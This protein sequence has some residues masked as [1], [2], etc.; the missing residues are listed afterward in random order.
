MPQYRITRPASDN[1]GVTCRHRP[2]TEVSFRFGGRWF[3]GPEAS[4][5]PNLSTISA[6]LSVTV[7]VQELD[8]PPEGIYQHLS[9][10]LHRSYT[11]LTSLHRTGSLNQLP[12]EAT[13]RNR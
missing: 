2:P 12:K 3:A 5:I 6:S 8:C 10:D 4:G 1:T 7:C 13:H 11:Q 9:P